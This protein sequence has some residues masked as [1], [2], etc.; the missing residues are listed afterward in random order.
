MHEW[1]QLLVVP[2]VRIWMHNVQQLIS[3]RLSIHK[4]SRESHIAHRTSTLP[5][6]PH[7]APLPRANKPTI[8]PLTRSS[9]TAGLLAL[10]VPASPSKGPDPLRPLPELLKLSEDPRSPEAVAI[11]AG[12]DKDKSPFFSI[13]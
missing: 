13:R 4:A 12:E 9:L 7:E 5:R 10:P 2:L 3:Y 6:Y 11:D 8:S 1:G